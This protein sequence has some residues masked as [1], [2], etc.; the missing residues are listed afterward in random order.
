[1]K[2]SECK[3]S[4]ID[5]SHQSKCRE[6]FDDAPSTPH[7]AILALIRSSFSA[8]LILEAVSF[9]TSI[10]STLSSSRVLLKRAEDPPRML[11]M[12]ECKL[13]DPNRVGD[14]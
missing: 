8:A 9:T 10:L 6:S 4:Q 12:A 11:A 5:R 3:I 7:S 13:I 1:M 14:P 2:Q